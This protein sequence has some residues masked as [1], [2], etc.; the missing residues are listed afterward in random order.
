[1]VGP[2]A[3]PIVY[4]LAQALT[5]GEGSIVLPAGRLF[6]LAVNTLALVAG[7]VF[8]AT[9]IGLATAWLTTRT[10][11][12]GARVWSTLTVL[13]LVIPSFVGALAL[14]GAT[15]RQGVISRALAQIGVGPLPIPHGY[16]GAFVALTMFTFP[17]VHLLAVPALRKLDAGFE[18]A[19]RGLGASPTRVFRTITLPQVGPSLRAAMLLVALYTMAD[20]GAVSLLRYDT[21]TR[22]I[23]LQYAGRLDRRP[24]TLLAG[25]LVVIALVVIWG[26]R[27]SRGRAAILGGRVLRS[28]RRVALTGWKRLAAFGFLGSMVTGSLVLPIAVLMGWWL[29]GAA[30]GQAPLAVWSETGRSLLVSAITAIVAAVAVLPIAI[31]TVRYR[32]R[33]G[34]VCESLAWSLYSLPHLTVG[35]A[36]L[37]MGLTVLTPFYQTLPLLLFAYLIMFLPQAMGPTQ[38][39]LGQVA[40]S[41]EEASRSLGRSALATTRRI[42][43]PLVGRGMLAGAGLV[44]LTTM[45]ELPATLLLRPT[46]FE[47]LAVRIW[48]TTSE[49]FYTRASMAALVLVAVSAVPLHLLVSRNTNE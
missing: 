33:V 8:A 6:Q 11:L 39:A 40:P 29:R 42:T 5:G 17:Y 7:V 10:D 47:T 34:A 28:P 25:T 22:A 30:A 45:K 49:G 1:M 21:F 36:V 19:A 15:G 44:F 3:L 27:R 13:P 48:S 9:S 46:G 38:A 32:S 24:A 2:L 4:L 12:T 20:F 35:L 37:L 14:L 43:V 26:E 31:L 23:F 18:E 16:F 41:L